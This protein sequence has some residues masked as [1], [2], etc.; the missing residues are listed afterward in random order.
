MADRDLALGKNHV[1]IAMD[2]DKRHAGIDSVLSAG[3]Q[4]ISQLCR[5]II[6][7]IEP[8]AVHEQ[9][10]A[11]LR[12]FEIAICRHVIAVVPAFDNQRIEV[13]F[14]G[15]PHAG[16]ASVEIALRREPVAQRAVVKICVGIPRIHRV[17]S[18]DGDLNLAV[19]D[20]VLIAQIYD[21]DALALSFINDLPEC[22]DVAPD[23]ATMARDR[24]RILAVKASG[25]EPR[26]RQDLVDAV[27]MVVVAM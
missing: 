13:V 16:V 21:R 12:R 26:I 15:A 6:V 1:D 14:V 4:E 23:R 27:A 7:P 19:L 20:L 8:A 9:P 2:I 5:E 18:I 10:Y 11:H 25:R 22:I 17:L 3:H 24:I